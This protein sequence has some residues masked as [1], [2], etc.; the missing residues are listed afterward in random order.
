MGI[1]CN[2]KEAAICGGESHATQQHQ[3]CVTWGR[4]AG[5]T[6]FS[7]GLVGGVWSGSRCRVWSRLLGVQSLLQA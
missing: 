6:S 3:P 2:Q 5:Q 1:C 7:S 4:S